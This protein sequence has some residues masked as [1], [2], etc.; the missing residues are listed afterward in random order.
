[1]KKDACKRLLVACLVA[2][3]A[4]GCDG[5]YDSPDH[6]PAQSGG[7]ALSEIDCRDYTQWVYINLDSLSA[8][9]APHDDTLHIPAVWHI[10]LHRYD[11]KTLGGKAVE[12][13]YGDL[14][15]LL[16]DL[17]NGAWALP[18]DS[19]WHADVADSI[20]VDMSTMMDGYLGMAPGTLNPVLCRWLHVDVSQM[21]PIYTPSN[22]VYLLRLPNGRTAA[23]RFTGYYS[24]SRHNE[25]GYVSLAWAWLPSLAPA[26]Q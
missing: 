5:I 15:A 1:M 20:V 3:T 12:T 21:P 4:M 18:A 7:L 22:K 24:P 14:S 17:A 2:A 13:T 9:A 10:A 25:K 8:T 26:A 11:V 6:Q 16:G 23:L 19:L